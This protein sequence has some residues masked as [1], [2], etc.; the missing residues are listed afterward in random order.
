MSLWTFSIYFFGSAT[1]KAGEDVIDYAQI[2]LGMLP[3][4]I[5]GLGLGAFAHGFRL[6]CI[7]VGLVSFVCWTCI[8]IADAS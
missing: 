1:K 7:A 4:A 8:I 3:L 6:L 5:A 2:S